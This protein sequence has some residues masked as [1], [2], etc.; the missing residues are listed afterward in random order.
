[1]TRWLT[2]WRTRS[3]KVRLIPFIVWVAILFGPAPFASSIVYA[4][5][6]PPGWH[7]ITVH[8]SSNVVSNY[9]V[10]S[11]VPGLILAY[12]DSLS[13]GWFG[14]GTF[15]HYQWRTFDGGAHWTTSTLSGPCAFPE[16]DYMDTCALAA[17]TGGK[18]TFF[19]GVDHDSYLIPAD[20][21][22][23]HDA[24]T[25]WRRVTTYRTTSS[26][27]DYFEALMNGVYRDGRLYILRAPSDDYAKGPLEFSVSADDGASWTATEAA[28]SGLERQGWHAI[29]FA[30]DYSAPH[31]WYRVLERVLGTNTVPP[32]LEHSTDDGRSWSAV[33]SFGGSGANLGISLG[34]NPD[35]PSR[36][37]IYLS[38]D[39]DR[40]AVL[41]SADGG[42]SF[43]T[44]TPPAQGH[45]VSGFHYASIRMGAHGDCY[46]A[47][48]FGT[49]LRTVLWSV[50]PG[51]SIMQPI[52]GLQEYGLSSSTFAYV[53]GARTM[54]S[55]LVVF[56]WGYKHPWY[57]WSSLLS[58][59]GRE[60]QDNLL[61]W[62]PV[63]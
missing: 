57:K 60:E 41:S 14:K 48:F 53:P 61:L 58:F 62:T 50:A 6:A 7:N 25:S 20:V 49:D 18:G 34:T 36:L 33:G 54:P 46:L 24:G 11:D 19:A 29:T 32:M 23:S 39:A 45:P 17:P 59:W 63:P 8:G 40:I 16:K 13:T 22:V 31:A 38:N 21:W 15:H 47:T 30:A 26:D 42:H 44:A 37:C 10:S 4:T 1:M 5:V 3:L 35:Q 51:A 2:F 9:V 55:R 56:T 27:K 28:P 52:A 12:G 43:V